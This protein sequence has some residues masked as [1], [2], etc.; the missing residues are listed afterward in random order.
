MMKHRLVDVEIRL[1]HNN[2]NNNMAVNEYLAENRKIEQY[3]RWKVKNFLNPEKHAH[4]VM[5]SDGVF[6]I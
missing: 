5:F 6:I 1:Y 4:H 2:N 3:K